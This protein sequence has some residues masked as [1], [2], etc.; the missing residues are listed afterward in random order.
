MKDNYDWQDKTALD[1]VAEVKETATREVKRHISANLPYF[2][3]ALI[4]IFD[5]F[6][7]FVQTGFSALT[8]GLV[9]NVAA[10]VAFSVLV[11]YIF[12][13]MGKK[14]KRQTLEATTIYDEWSGLCKRIRM[15]GLLTTFR[16]YCRNRADREAVAEYEAMIEELE[17]M[18]VS[19]EDF[20]QLYRKASK[21]ELKRLNRN[22]EL[23][24]AAYDQ[25]IRLRKPIK[26][27]VY[28]PLYILTSSG[29]EQRSALNGKDRHEAMVL[30][31]KPIITIAVGVMLDITTLSQKNVD[32]WV[33]AIAAIC[34]SIF[35]IVLSAV[36]GY[37]SGFS[38][39]THA[40][41]IVAAKSAFIGE[42]Y[43]QK[44]S[45]AET[46]VIVVDAKKK[47]V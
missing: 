2:C 35:K 43:E 9:F 24:D 1:K 27:A 40:V 31:F 25:I 36:L 6:N 45:A 38:V 26:K 29:S 11:F 37:F 12:F 7:Q 33:V 19:R 34:L 13:P 14:G 17:N 10:S 23:T 5:I 39:E 15:E 21:R 22:G 20:E 47:A 18:Y 3:L 41:G 42:F 28:N 32:S 8:I 30:A 4:A 16:A 46:A 44:D